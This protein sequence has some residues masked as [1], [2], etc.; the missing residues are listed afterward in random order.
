MKLEKLEMPV[1]NKVLHAYQQNEAFLYKY[2]DYRNEEKSYIERVKELKN[3]CFQRQ[4][5]ADVIRTFMTPFGLSAAADKHLNELVED[6]AVTIVGGQQAGVL[7]GPL[8]S[9]H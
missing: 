2:F 7:T 5:L 8:Y 6:E 9:V 1:Q 3:R 4:E